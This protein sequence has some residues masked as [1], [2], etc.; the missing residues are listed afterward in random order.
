MKS[1]STDFSNRKSAREHGLPEAWLKE[2]PAHVTHHEAGHVLAAIYGGFQ[3]ERV[4]VLTRS[5]SD[6]G[7]LGSDMIR[8]NWNGA[9]QGINWGS[10]IPF[11]GL[12]SVRRLDVKVARD[13][14]HRAERCLMEATA[15]VVAEAHFEWDY[16]PCGHALPFDYSDYFSLMEAQGDNYDDDT[17]ICQILCRL[18]DSEHR[19]R[20][21]V[22]RPNNE[23]KP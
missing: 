11:G 4:V 12:A 23:R 2:R 5:Q 15:G 14:R 13:Y 18:T 1:I 20:S 17:I 7:L 19:R 9:I 3:F 21:Y 22:V 16:P 8:R 10:S 6:R